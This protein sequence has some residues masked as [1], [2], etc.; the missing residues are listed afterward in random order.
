MI[1]LFMLTLGLVLAASPA[2]AE[3]KVTLNPSSLTVVGTQC[4]AFFKCPPV[5]RNLLVKTNE[6]IT[7]LQVITLDLIAQIRLLLFQLAPSVLL[8]LLNSVTTKATFDFPC[9]I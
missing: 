4:P 7:D 8:Y 9:R 5:K 2:Q 3:A 1:S 6:V